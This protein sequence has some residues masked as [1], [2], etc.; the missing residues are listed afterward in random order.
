MP[1]RAGLRNSSL[2]EI[3]LDGVQRGGV[4]TATITS[5]RDG[6]VAY[7]AELKFDES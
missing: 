5:L 2:R 1:K 6:T 7:R 3:Y 4:V